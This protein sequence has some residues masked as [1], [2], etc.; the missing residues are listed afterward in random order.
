MVPDTTMKGTSGARA[1]VM[2]SSS[3]APSRGTLE[4]ESRA[5]N[6]GSAAQR[7]GPPA[8]RLAPTPARS[9]SHGAAAI[10]SFP[11]VSQSLDDQN[12]K[13]SAVLTQAQL[14]SPSPIQSSAIV[15]AGHGSLEAGGAGRRGYDLMKPQA[16][17]RVVT[18]EAEDCSI[19]WRPRTSHGPTGPLRCRRVSG[20]TRAGAAGPRP[21]HRAWRG[22]SLERGD[23]RPQPPRDPC[24]PIG[25]VPHR[26]LLNRDNPKIR[27]AFEPR[28]A[29]ERTRIATRAALSRPAT[30]M[31]EPTDRRSRPRLWSYDST[32]RS[33]R[34]KETFVRTENGLSHTDGGLS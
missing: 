21:A 28:C 4:S 33:L 27:P 8:S 7:G 6:C 31:C 20:P 26:P 32:A 10:T 11:S 22:A 16:L 12:P 19:V 30:G 17:R 14:P 1:F 2:V 13:P 34:I 5:A 15:Q 9:R 23:N 25:A 29:T 24:E 18:I 3:S